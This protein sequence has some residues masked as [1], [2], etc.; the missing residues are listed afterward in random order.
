MSSLVAGRGRTR[1]D[2]S[3]L[4]GHRSSRAREARWGYA[5][6]SPWL[7]GTACLTVVPMVLS[8]YYAFTRYD[9]F[10][11]PQWVGLRNYAELVGDPLFWRSLRTTATYTGLSVP[12]SLALSMLCAVL[13]N[14]KVRGR[15]IF[16]GIFFFSS[17]IPGVA[18][19][20]LWLWILNPEYGLL[21]AAL[22][23][24]GIGRHNWLGDP[25]TAL[26]AVVVIALWGSIGGTMM[27]TFLAALQSVPRE[28]YEAARLEGAGMFREFVSIT[29]PMISPTVFFNLIVAT[30]GS[31]TVFDI[32][33]VTTGG[34]PEYSTYTY[35]MHI[36]I[37]GFQNFDFGMASAL[38]WVLTLVLFA[39]S[40][41]LFRLQRRWV[42]YGTEI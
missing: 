31:F 27:I 9:V 39:L 40:A 8:F 10:S 30:I 41:L 42:Y 24:A 13:L 18:C 29:V 38:I 4:V 35:F 26:P 19:A 36:Y 34:G 6:I 33:Y 23:Y 12:L 25:S 28:L 32:V 3:I 11:A 1:R 22:G 15:T 7:V 20:F 17:I 16:R 37:T 14:A 2:G 5:F 21:N